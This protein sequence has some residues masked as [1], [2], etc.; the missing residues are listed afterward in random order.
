M[1]DCTELQKNLQALQKTLGLEADDQTAYTIQLDGDDVT[2][3]EQA[4]WASTSALKEAL[5]GD[6]VNPS[7]II[8]CQPVL[9]LSNYVKTKA[10][11]KI[12]AVLSKDEIESLGL[13][14]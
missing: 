13:E 3:I 2:L 4:C 10:M 8:Q 14:E 6:C 1:I 12:K 5:I 7:T 11:R 9:Q